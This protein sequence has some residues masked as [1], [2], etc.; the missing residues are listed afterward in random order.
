[1]WGNF[2]VP[3]GA[4][5]V[6]HNFQVNLLGLIDLLSNH[7]YSGPEV[8]IREL[9]QNGVD[10]IRARQKIEPNVAGQISL[11]VTSSAGRVPTLTFTDN[12]IGL[13]EDEAHRFL[14]VIGESS[15]RG[16]L[17]DRPT[18]FLGQFGIGLLA[19][20]LVSD[21]IVVISRSASGAAPVQWR[22]KPDG[23]YE[24]KTLDQ[25]L[26]TGTQ[27]FLRCK[28]GMEE[29]FTLARLTELARSYGGLLPFPIRVTNGRESETVN[30][31][32][33]PW[34]QSFPDD[35]TRVRELLKFG[36]ELFESRFLDAIPLRSV[37]GEADGVAFVLAHS[38]SAVAKRSDRV[39]LKQM[40]LTESA[41]NLLPDWA[42]FVK[43]VVNVNGLRPTASRES[44]YEDDRL[45]EA[46]AAL[47]DCLRN[48]LI[49]LAEQR[50]EKF[51]DLLSLHQLAIEALA[52]EDDECFQLFIDYLPFETAEGRMTL[53]EFLE[54]HDAVRYVPDIDQFR[55]VA[56]VA[57]SQGLGVINA[58]YIYVPELLLKYAEF[59]PEVNV[60]SL[61]SAD[62]AQV[63]DEL[64]DDEKEI[65]HDFLAAA[66][67]VLRPLRCT[68]DLRRF[69]PVELTALYSTDAE[70]R[71]LRSVEQSQQ[72]A[73]SLWSGVLS[74]L[75]K[76][77]QAAPPARLVF[78]YEN[79]LVRRLVQA[80]AA[81]ALRP[82][83]QMLYVQALLLAHQPLSTR[84]WKLMNDGLLS[85]VE[86]S[87]SQ[88]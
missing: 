2:S 28:P 87:F 84:E 29:F 44:F 65:A 53:P 62:V 11:E 27:V 69:R 76:S 10:A 15:K 57:S 52:V 74:N 17:D 56:R 1:L 18:D 26:T 50:P 59:H 3:E 51:R 41:D 66:D 34:R 24:I 5:S 13:T 35:R 43:A 78:N 39:Y 79:P 55:Q 38:P 81:A 32:E 4:F 33:L 54:R 25:D 16:K 58:G 21:E 72:A 7:L 23:T 82:A 42:F 71:F 14:A 46:R 68:A 19:C 88:E 85:L 61:D 49:K 83:V 48:Y 12:G 45:D 77:H 30:V 31:D 6:S 60:S 8:F 64:D 36:E 47:G 80:S 70:G 37:A 40:L 22:G 63:L 75:S 9:L 67:S 20:F 86:A 73:D